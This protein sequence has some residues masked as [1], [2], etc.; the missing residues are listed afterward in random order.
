[1]DGFS[2]TLFRGKRFAVVGL[3]KNGL[4]AALGL[5][6]MGAEVVAWDDNAAARAG[7]TGVAVRDPSVGP[8]DFDALVLSP[9]IP[10]RLP[11]PHPAAER[12]LAA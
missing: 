5:R 4:P 8:F 1:M 12:A 6:A 2:G 11:R 3:G 7:A 10:H 9:G